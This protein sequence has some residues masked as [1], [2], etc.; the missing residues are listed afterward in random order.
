MYLAGVGLEDLET[1]ER[2][3]S[4]SNAVARLIRHASYFHY[5][6]FIDLPFQQWDDDKYLELRKEPP[7]D[8]LKVAYIEVLQKLDQ[9][10]ER[11]GSM[12]TV[13]CLKHTPS[14]LA[15]S[16]T[17]SAAEE[18]EVK[19]LEAECRSTFHKLELAM[20]VVED[21]ERWL[22]LNERWTHEHPAYQEAAA[23][24]NNLWKQLEGLVVARLF[25][26]AKANLMGTC[27]KMCN[28]HTMND[29]PGTKC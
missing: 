13:P 11:W 20:N 12:T 15:P 4:A 24:I 29:S 9:Q 27:Y 8:A 16:G 5:L 22:G 23:Y 28:N 7:E 26:L 6:Q 18:S 1:C 14:S 21:I 3:F 25:E 19:A 10:N 2:L 17:L